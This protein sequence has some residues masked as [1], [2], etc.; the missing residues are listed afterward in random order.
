TRTMR[1]EIDVP[2]PGQQLRP[3]M[4]GTATLHLRKPA[5]GAVRL[6]ASCVVA[7][8]GG[9]RAVYV[10]RDGKARRAEGQVG[11]RV[12]KEVEVLSGLKPADQVVADPTGLTGEV[13]PVE[14]KDGPGAK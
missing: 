4:F 9:K 7:A 11:H 8:P 5:P 1:V 2:N 13:V 14:V 10:V 3:G 12:G 6:P